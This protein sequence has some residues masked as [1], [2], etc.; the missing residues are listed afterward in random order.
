MSKHREQ[1]KASTSTLM[2]LA[3]DIVTI[4]EKNLIELGLPIDNTALVLELASNAAQS[5]KQ[6]DIHFG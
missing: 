2:H 3:A 1:Q 6:H 4:T 5:K